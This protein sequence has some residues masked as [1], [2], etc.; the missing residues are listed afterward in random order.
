MPFARQRRAEVNRATVL[1]GTSVHLKVERPSSTSSN[2]NSHVLDVG[3]LAKGKT[4]MIARPKWRLSIGGSR[5]HSKFWQ[6]GQLVTRENK[7]QPQASTMSDGQ[8][9]FLRE[10]LMETC[11]SHQTK[12]DCTSRKLA[13]AFVHGLLCVW[14]QQLCGLAEDLLGRVQLTCIAGVCGSFGPNLGDLRCE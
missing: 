1:S 5:N 6:A 11:V 13:D 8:G 12:V 10:S 9:A 7:V 2:R 4:I 14:V 3:F